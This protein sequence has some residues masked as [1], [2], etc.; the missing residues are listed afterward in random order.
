MPSSLRPV[1]SQ[2]GFEKVSGRKLYISFVK[3]PT[4][5]SHNKIVLG[6]EQAKTVLGVNFIL[7]NS[8]SE[9]LAASPSECDCIWTQGLERGK[10]V[11]F[12]FLFFFVFLG[13]H[14]QHV[15][16]PRLGVN[17]SYCW[18]TPQPHQ[19]GIRAA[20]ATYTTGHGNAG[21]LTHRARPAMEPMFSWILV[22]LSLLSHTGNSRRF[23]LSL[24]FAPY[25]W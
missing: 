18:P 13:P 25:S 7:F 24:H 15:E 22:G 2:S 23:C 1:W 19:L 10:Q 6:N 16:V 5:P 21:S 14:L 11:F 20:S 17:Q 12:F 9:V 3:S 4:K 8:Y